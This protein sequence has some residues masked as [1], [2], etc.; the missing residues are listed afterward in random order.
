MKITALIFFFILIVNIT[1][2]SEEYVIGSDDLLAIEVWKEDSLTKDFTVGQDGNVILPYLNEVKVVGL[3]TQAAA[4]LIANR[5]KNE[6]FLVNPVV[7]VSVKE[8][9]SQRI[10]VFGPVKKPGTHYLKGKTTVL[11]FLSQI[12][13]PEGKGGKMVILRKEPTGEENTLNV[14]LHALILS[15]DLS[16][17]VEILGGDK[18]IIS[19]IVSSGQQI[20]VLG[21]VNIPGP[22]AVEKDMSVL[23]VLRMAGGFTDF[24]NKNRVK[25]IREA[26]GKKKNIFVNL[27]KIA[28]GDKTEDIILQPSDVLVALKSWF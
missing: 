10:M 21:E 12:S 26:D 4:E 22:Y 8:Y 11:D 28:K 25:I 7:A 17:N 13:Y 16:Q 2:F 5:L 27:N 15:G 9:H 19:R 14:D 1:I 23:E 18:I 6:G 3:T 24:A 20:Y